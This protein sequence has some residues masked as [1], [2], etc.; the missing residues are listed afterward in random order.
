MKLSEQQIQELGVALNE[1]TLLG[2]EASPE[3]KLVSATFAVLTLPESGSPPQDTR[4]QIVL[5]SVDRIAASLRLG[6]WDDRSAKVEQIR[7]EQLLEIAQSFRRPIYGWE[8]F[9]L[10]TTKFDWF[11]RL[12][13][14]WRGA[15][16]EPQNSF[17]FF[18]DG[19]TRH[20]DVCVWFDSFTIRNPDGGEIPL[21]DFISGGKRWW[22]AMYARDSRTEGR[23][24]F[25][26][27]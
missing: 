15:N 2:I 23:G 4:V 8:F 17:S 24:I 21:E 18:Q 6:R 1:A 11:D 5:N 20:L 9:N 27:K 3:R 13:L 26:V 10:D 14:D 16:A 19:G 25:P 7:I 22:D 12:S